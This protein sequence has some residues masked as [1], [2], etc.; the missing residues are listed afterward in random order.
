MMLPDCARNAVLLASIVT[1][2]TGSTQLSAAPPPTVT[3]TLAEELHGAPL[4]AYDQAKELFEHQDFSTAHARFKQAYDLS[5]NPRLLWNM[6]ACSSKAKRYGVAID[7][8]TRFLTEGRGRISADQQG[9]AEQMIADLRKLV[10][11]VRV[12]ITPV[13]ASLSVDAEPK[14]AMTAATSFLLEVGRHEL[15]AEKSGYEPRDHVF[16]ITEPKLVVVRLD[17]KA[18]IV[19]PETPVTAR[20]VVVTDSEGVVELDGKALAKGTFDAAV[21]PGAH[22]L[23]IA[24]SGKKTYDGD[25]D[26]AAGSTRQLSVTLVSDGALSTISGDQ[27]SG[28]SWWPWAV[29]GAVVAA[30]AG[31][32]G[33]YLLKPADSQKQPL[34]GS[35]G[36]MWV[37]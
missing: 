36:T 7:E 12:E 28:S 31:V 13:G 10:A 11:E 15:R 20:L 22:H 26:L 35:L 27:A 4:E 1:L 17:L 30:G 19:A 2:L 24:A 21:R 14:G 29:G 37:N 8:A 9:R 3:K 18:V 5:K 6:A 32:G 33:Y 25:L 23:R 16:T 34:A